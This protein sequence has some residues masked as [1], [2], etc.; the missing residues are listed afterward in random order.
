MCSYP[1]IQAQPPAVWEVDSPASHANIRALHLN[2]SSD[3]P[4]LLPASVKSY[5]LILLSHSIFIALFRGLICDCHMLL[6]EPF[7]DA[8][9][10]QPLGPVLSKAASV[11]CISPVSPRAPDARMLEELD[12]EPWYQGEMSRKEAEA[13][14]QEDGDFLVRKSTTNPGSFV[15]TGMHNGQA[16]H[17]LLVDPE[18]TVSTFQWYRDYL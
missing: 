2:P 11:E 9:K 14:L 12:A 1:R 4:F 10:N 13:L 17:L 16:K 6:T 15:L 5:I 8:L 7:E 18:G 3:Y